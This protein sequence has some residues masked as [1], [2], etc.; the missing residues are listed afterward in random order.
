MISITISLAV[1]GMSL[2][3][4]YTVSGASTSGPS[5][6]YVQRTMQKYSQN[7]ESG[8]FEAACD[9]YGEDNSTVTWTNG[10]NGEKTRDEDTRVGKEEIKDKFKWLWYGGP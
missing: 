1:F 2:S 4:P 8:N 9:L 10:R 3:T 7:Y 5:Y 6:T